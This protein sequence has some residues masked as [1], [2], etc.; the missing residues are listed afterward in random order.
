MENISNFL[1]ASRTL[2][3]A[4]HDLFETVDLFE[5]KDLGVVVSCIHALGRTVQNTVPTYA[6]PK[7]GA[8][9][10]GA[11]AAKWAQKNKTDDYVG[12]GMTKL[13]MGS[14]QTMQRQ[15]MNDTR[16]GSE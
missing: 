14:S 10:G 16:Y 15:T 1:K 2:G 4:E 3:L 6:G 12:K 5:A 9:S 11:T 7:L 8:K 13:S